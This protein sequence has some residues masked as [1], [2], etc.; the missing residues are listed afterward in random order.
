MRRSCAVPELTVIDGACSQCPAMASGATH[1]SRSA[2]ITGLGNVPTVVT[3]PVPILEV[4]TAAKR[5][6]SGW[7]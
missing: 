7:T 4:V 2:A 1:L 6:N 5:P 3:R